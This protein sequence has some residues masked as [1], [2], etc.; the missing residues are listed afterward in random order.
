MLNKKFQKSEINRNKMN[1][2]L[3]VQS[4]FSPRQNNKIIN[5]TPQ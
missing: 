5:P 2:D 1:D 4:V 3:G